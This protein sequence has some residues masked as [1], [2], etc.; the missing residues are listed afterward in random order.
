MD[1]TLGAGSAET[2]VWDGEQYALGVAVETSRSNFDLWAMHIGVNGDVGDRLFVGRTTGDRPDFA[3]FTTSDRLL[4]AYPRISFE[5]P[6]DGVT[7][8]FVR[9]PAAPIRSRA[10]QH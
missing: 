5:A 9:E 3:L 1:I 6:Y 7:R 8:I 2:L 4:A 10:I